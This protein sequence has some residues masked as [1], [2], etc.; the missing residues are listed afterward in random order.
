MQIDRVNRKELKLLAHLID[1]PHTVSQ[2]AEDSGSSI[3]WTSE[4][5]SRLEGMG[6]VKKQKTGV[7]V[8]IG[9]TEDRLGDDLRLLMTESAYMDLSKVLAGP[10][11]AILPLLL[12]PGSTMREMEDRTHISTKTIRTKLKQWQGMGLA[13]LTV[14]PPRYILNE[15]WT[16]LRRFLVDYVSER[17]LRWLRSKVPSATMIW[18]WRDELLF[19]V[20]DK[21]EDPEFRSAG[22]TRLE[23]LGYDI[24]HAREYYLNREGNVEVSEEEALVQTLRADPENPRGE[25]FIR[26]ALLDKRVDAKVLIKYAGMYGLKTRLKRL[27][28]HHGR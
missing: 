21:L 14:N 25:R 8:R 24:A 7:T 2:L 16:Y 26:Q 9:L 15:S 18:Q 19:S 27:A 23:E 22:A 28:S 5:V 10:G 13:S 6:L 20:G 11:L 12:P 17:N 3:S 4:R 1:G